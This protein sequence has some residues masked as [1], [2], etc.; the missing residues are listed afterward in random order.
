MPISSLRDKT[1]R[2]LV[3]LTMNYFI[4]PSFRYTVE[5]RNVL[6]VSKDFIP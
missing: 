6:T 4:T 1:T 3:L 2:P 5:A